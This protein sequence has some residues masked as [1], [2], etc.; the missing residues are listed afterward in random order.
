MHPSPLTRPAARRARTPRSQLRGGANRRASPVP[1]TPE[2]SESRH[3]RVRRASSP[4]SPPATRPTSSPWAD[5][6]VAAEAARLDVERVPRSSRPGTTGERPRSADRAPPLRVAARASHARA[7]TKLDRTSSQHLAPA[8]ILREPAKRP[9]PPDATAQRATRA[10]RRPA[11]R[12]HKS[13]GAPAARPGAASPPHAEAP[14]AAAP[15]TAGRRGARPSP[16]AAVPETSGAAVSRSTQPRKARTPP[17]R[18]SVQCRAAGSRSRRDER[19]PRVAADGGS[20]AG[21]RGADQ[22]AAGDRERR[23]EPHGSA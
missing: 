17:G 23:S 12:L 3:A 16:P 11:E 18:W 4:A 20:Q 5:R 13:P 15:P 8:P 7:P 10:S 19:P 6:R 2:R 22:S 1:P 14:A 9:G 21:R